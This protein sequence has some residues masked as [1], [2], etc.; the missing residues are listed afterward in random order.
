MS[1]RIEGVNKRMPPCEYPRAQEQKIQETIASSKRAFYEHMEEENMSPLDFLAVQL[2]LMGKRIWLLQ[3]IIFVLLWLSLYLQTGEH[4]S[5]G[6]FSVWVPLLGMTL[7]P[8]LW[9]NLKNRAVE[10]E[11][12]TYFGLKKIYT[13][14]ILL[15]GMGELLLVSAFFICAAVTV[16]ASLFEVMINFLL[17]FN[18]TC[19]ICFAV[20][21]SMK[22]NSELLAAGLCVLW[23]LLWYRVVVAEKLYRTIAPSIWLGLVVVSLGFM[24]YMIGRSVKTAA[25]YCEGEW[26]WNCK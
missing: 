21:C 26:L 19:C 9:K 24:I 20:L 8:E 22:I 17:P 6:G 16:R 14:R 12:T 2:Q 7:I 3:I 5:Y 4:L 23:S 11:N 10:I 13:A 25:H 18:V 15:M 1:E